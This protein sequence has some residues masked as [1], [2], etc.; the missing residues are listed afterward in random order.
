MI[1]GSS[2]DPNRSKVTVGEL[3]DQ[4][5]EAKLDLAPKT[6]ERYRGIIDPRSGHGG[7]THS[8][9]YAMPTFSAGSLGSILHRPASARR[10]E[11]SRWS[12]PT[13]SEMVD[14]RRTRQPGS[15]C[16]ASDRLRD[17]F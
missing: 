11:C 10:T 17:V 1:T 16:R 2:V 9:P 3:T 14:W 7:I 13:P 8:T 15:A 6:R 4:W 12:W 5:L